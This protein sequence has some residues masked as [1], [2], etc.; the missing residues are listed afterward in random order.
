VEDDIMNYTI[1]IGCLILV[2]VMV[3]IILNINNIKINKN[4]IEINKNQIEFNKKIL[5]YLES[6]P[7]YEEVKKNGN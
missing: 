3:Q 4:N 5:S 7:R 2:F 6:M 1:L